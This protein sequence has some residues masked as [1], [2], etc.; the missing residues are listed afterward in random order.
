M[1][2]EI[3]EPDT[4]QSE[5][6]RTGR[7]GRVSFS[8]FVREEL[9]CLM[10]HSRQGVDGYAPHDCILARLTDE[11][12]DRLPRALAKGR[13]REFIEYVIAAWRYANAGKPRMSDD[14]GYPR[15]HS[16]WRR[17]FAA[18]L[19]LQRDRDDDTGALARL[20]MEAPPNDNGIANVRRLLSARKND[21][22]HEV[23]V[24]CV[25]PFL[26][27]HAIA[28]GWE[29]SSDFEDGSAVREFNEWR[30]SNKSECRW[31]E[32]AWMK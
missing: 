16:G 24:Q 21:L 3:I 8:R 13:E 6:A 28:N 31:R 20:V 18:W 32:G 26:G 23:Y 27:A 1:S 5:Q 15:F 10:E 2:F 14:G 19:V 9:S 11:Q 25:R 22:A 30:K 17:S 7:M 12:L 4:E 29:N